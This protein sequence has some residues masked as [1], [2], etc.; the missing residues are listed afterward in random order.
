[1]SE[2]DINKPIN[3]IT[4]NDTELLL[5]GIV[6]SGTIPIT[7]NGYHNVRIY[8][9]VNVDVPTGVFPTGELEITENGTYD[10]TNYASANVNVASSGSGEDRLQWVCDNVKSLAYV[11]QNYSG[12]D[13]S[14]A[15]SGLNAS[16]VMSLA[17]TFDG[18]NYLQ[19]L[20][21]SSWHISDRLN[22]MGYCFRNCT[23]LTRLN[24]SNWDT[25]KVSNMTNA[26]NSCKALIEIAGAIDL[27]REPNVNNFFY[28]CTNL[29]TFT[30]KNI[31]KSLTI[32][33]GTN[34]GTKLD[35]PTIINTGMELHDLTGSSS[36]TLTVA[37]PI[38]ARLNEIYVK[39]IT[40]TEEMI[41]NDPYITSKKPC[42]VCT[43][44][45]EGAMTLREY[46]VS[47][48]WTISG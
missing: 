33:T 29:T 8:E 12:Y 35:D 48:N 25:S 19:E 1:M 42:E 15:V 47:K 20:D 27:F 45:D 30:L 41:A 17:Y 13:L 26:F 38:S 46:I 23:S 14:P 3:K 22:A 34:Y 5:E 2:I 40:A 21:L 36:Q 6:P 11:F 39:L 16:N 24:M 28:N 43:S 10:V 9:G 31:K 4:Y 18:C 32:G 7:N 44:T 37:T